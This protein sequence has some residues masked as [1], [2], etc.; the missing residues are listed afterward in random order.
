MED[1]IAFA[2]REEYEGFSGGNVSLVEGELFDVGTV[3]EAGN[4]RIVLGP[5]PRLGE[6][7]DASNAESLRANRDA[8]I[9]DALAQ[10]PAL[11]RVEVEEG[12]EPSSFSEVDVTLDAGATLT[13]L[14]AR[15]SELD[16]DGRSSMN[17]EELAEAI[18]QEEARLASGEPAEVTADDDAEGAIDEASEDESSTEGSGD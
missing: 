15:A 9:A 1:F 8:E 5:A 11:E 2:L 10:Y 7:G 16:I 6:G 14:R 12:E 17:K 13:E 18:A 4:G 3:I